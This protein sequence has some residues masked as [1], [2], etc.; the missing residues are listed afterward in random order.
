MRGDI[1]SQVEYQALRHSVDFIAGDGRLK[2][3][4]ARENASMDAR[5][6]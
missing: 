1:S 6:C 5:C 2:P 3:L 4:S